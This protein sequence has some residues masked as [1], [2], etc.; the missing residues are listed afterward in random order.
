MPT[1]SRPGMGASMRML[2]AARAM[3]R[4]SAR[5]SMRESLMRTSGRTSYCVTTGPVLVA[6]TVGRDLE[7]A[8]LLLDDADVAR[9]VVAAGLGRLGGVSSS[10]T[11]GSCQAFSRRRRRASSP[12]S[13][14]Q[15]L[16]AQEAR[17]PISPSCS[18]ATPADAEAPSTDAGVTGPAAALRGAGRPGHH[19]PPSGG[20]AGRARGCRPTRM[21]LPWP[22]FAAAGPD[23]LAHRRRAGHGSGRSGG[24]SIDAAPGGRA[25]R[26]PRGWPPRRDPRASR[27]RTATAALAAPA[28]A[29][30]AAARPARAKGDTKRH[31]GDVE[32]QQ[33][34]DEHDG[35]RG[36]R[37]RRPG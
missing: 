16:A 19:E 34:A 29:A 13:E 3:A 2:R 27:D 17:P 33:D 8:Q 31:E 26:A 23:R 18:V 22:L 4:S 37:R 1:T 12:G 36:R 24:G 30:P 11:L 9:V 15:P 32:E 6:T 28:P 35:P 20:G 5:P 14:R 10:V 7:A 21:P 25:S